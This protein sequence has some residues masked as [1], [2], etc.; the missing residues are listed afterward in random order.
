[1]QKFAN[2]RIAVDGM[3]KD[4]ASTQYKYASDISIEPSD[5]YLRMNEK[6]FD[7]MLD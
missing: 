1:M 5:T 3:E 6:E 4:R 2:A 7:L